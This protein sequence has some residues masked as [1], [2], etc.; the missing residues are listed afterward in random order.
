MGP[1]S[2]VEVFFALLLFK[3]YSNLAL[4]S[5]DVFQMIKP[6]EYVGEGFGFTVRLAETQFMI[7]KLH[8][9]S[10][11][12]HIFRYCAMPIEHDDILR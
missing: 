1:F 12:Y 10:E 7:R 3:L 9:V 2:V 6:M 8:H 5:D 11:I 4:Y